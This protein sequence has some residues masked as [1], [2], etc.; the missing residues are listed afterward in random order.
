MKTMTVRTEIGADG[1]LH[2]DVPCDLPPGPAEVVLVVQ[3]VS[4]TPGPPYDT[5]RGAL[6]GVMPDDVD[7]E[8]DLVE[9]N[10]EWKKK[11]DDL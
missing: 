5:L 1:A 11:L 9:M 4:G 8:A 2:L 7:V 10:R 3:P 6:A